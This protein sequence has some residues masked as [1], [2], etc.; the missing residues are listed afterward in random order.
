[1]ETESQ[2]WGKPVRTVSGSN[3]DLLWEQ[4]RD[5]GFHVVAQGWGR[6]QAD[7]ANGNSGKSTSAE[8]K[9]IRQ[10]GEMIS[11]ERNA[12][13]IPAQADVHHVLIL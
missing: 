6:D 12:I 8:G 2:G 9:K 13:D 3:C 10:Q 1:M 5:R 4:H 7:S 11:E